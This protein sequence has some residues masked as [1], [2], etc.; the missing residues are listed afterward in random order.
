MAEGIVYQDDKTPRID[1]DHALRKRIE[2]GFHASGNNAGGVQL[3]ECAFHEEEIAHESRDTDKRQEA[4]A[5]IREEPSKGGYV[6]IAKRI[7][8]HTLPPVAG[9]DREL[10]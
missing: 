1:H 3:T 5:R 9:R 8:Q 4:H 10:E 2:C 6:R 7:M